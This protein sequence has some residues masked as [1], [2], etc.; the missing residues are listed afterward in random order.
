MFAGEITYINSPSRHQASTSKSKH[1]QGVV[2]EMR[3]WAEIERKRRIQNTPR[4]AKTEVAK[5]R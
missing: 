5:V 4:E 3:S 2:I 1:I